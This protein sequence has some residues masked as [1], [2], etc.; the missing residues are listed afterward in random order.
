MSIDDK[1]GLISDDVYTIKDIKILKIGNQYKCFKYKENGLKDLGIDNKFNTIYRQSSWELVLTTEDG[2]DVCLVDLYNKNI[3]TYSL[4]EIELVDIYRD[5]IH[6]NLSL[7][8]IN[9]MQDEKS[10][11]KVSVYNDY[12][13]IQTH[14]KIGNIHCICDTNCKKWILSPL[15]NADEVYNY[16]NGISLASIGRGLRLIYCNKVIA[17]GI[18]RFPDVIHYND[19]IYLNCLIVDKED[20]KLIEI[21]GSEARE[22]L[23]FRG[24]LKHTCQ[25]G[26][27][28]KEEWDKRQE[29][30]N[31]KE[32]LIS[33]KVYELIDL[34]NYNIKKRVKI[35]LETYENYLS[36]NYEYWKDKKL[37]S[38]TNKNE[39]EIVFMN[40]IDG[41]TII[42]NKE[43]IIV[44]GDIQKRLVLINIKTKEIY[45]WYY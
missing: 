15:D 4:N 33:D 23:R 3:Y 10:K 17:D 34:K 24:I 21:K 45:I 13:Y 6:R 11:D 31:N 42:G 12:L 27:I 19:A 41:N 29:Y 36:Y 22:V 32:N 8:L 25:E 2:N 28:L 44:Y 30:S 7:E 16:R 39:Q 18:C 37:M 9:D 5:Y 14:S 38:Y 1:I 40:T 26:I 43:D 35:L 20:N